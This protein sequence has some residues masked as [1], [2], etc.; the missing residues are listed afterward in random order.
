MSSS[1]T[2]AF[3][4]TISDV[5]VEAFDRC[6]IRP[7]ALTRHHMTSARRSANLELQSWTNRGVDLFQVAFATLEIQDGVSTYTTGTDDD[8][9][10]TDIQ[11][12]LDVYYSTINGGGA[13]QD[14]DRIML[15][16]SRTEYAGYPNKAQTGIPTV[17]WYQK[18][19]SPQLTIWQPPVTGAPTNVIKY[20]Y[21]RRIEDASIAGGQ[22]PDIPYRAIDAFCAG[23]ARRLAKKFV[24]DKTLRDEI[25]KDATQ[26][27]IEFADADNE[28]TSVSISGDFSRYWGT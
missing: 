23:M 19:I 3:E 8:E 13:G 28:G 1:G 22:T 14:I 18:L 27:W 7:S 5:V 20:Y 4:L 21:L 11:S 15:P 6:F 25:S 24:T 2:T 16:I 12:M 26:A 10:P 9:I 17:Y